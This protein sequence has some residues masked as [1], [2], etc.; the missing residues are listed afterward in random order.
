MCVIHSAGIHYDAIQKMW[1]TQ[2]DCRLPT[3]YDHEQ[4]QAMLQQFK[5]LQ[6]EKPFSTPQFIGK[7]NLTNCF[8]RQ[9]EANATQVSRDERNEY[10]GV[11][12]ERVNRILEAF[13][14]EVATVV[15]SLGSSRRTAK[16]RA[17]RAS[18]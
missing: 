11:T 5:Q 6:K 8:S 1:R 7:E 16:K 4:T 17:S 2:A 15:E 14:V 13:E 12:V 10:H 18:G 9:Q 3:P